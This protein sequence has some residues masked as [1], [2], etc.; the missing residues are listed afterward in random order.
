M[1]KRPAVDEGD[2]TKRIK[3]DTTLQSWRAQLD[4]IKKSGASKEQ[5]SI[6]FKSYLDKYVN[7]GKVLAMYIN[8]LMDGEEI[9]K[10]EIEKTFSET[11][12]RVLNIDL[13]KCYLKYIQLINPITPDSTDLPRQTVIKAYQFAVDTIG[14]DP[15]NGSEIWNDYL[16]YLYHW[17]CITSQESTKRQD[18][19]EKTL[20]K[21]IQTPSSNLE[22]HWKLFTSFEN[23]LNT[24]K[25][26]KVINDQSPIYMKLRSINN[27]LKKIIGSPC[28][29]IEVIERKET[30]QISIW[31][32]WL[33]WEFKNPLE[34]NEKALQARISLVYNLSCQY[35]KLNPEVWFNYSN[36]VIIEL[37]NLNLGKEILI[38]CLKINPTSLANLIKL[39]NIYESNNETEK[40]NPIWQSLV[41]HLID[42][43]FDNELITYC[44][45]NWMKIW[46]KLNNL[47]QIRFVFSQARKFTDIGFKIYVE[48]AMIEHSNNDNKIAIKAF[49]LG[50]KYFSNS[51][52]MVL[53]YLNFLIEIKDL[54]NFKKIIEI[55][56]ENFTNDDDLIKLFIKY[57]QV[58]SNFGNLNSINLL[59]KR[60][61]TK[62]PTSTSFNL[63][64]LS[65]T[66]ED[67]FN[68][69]LKLDKYKDSNKVDNLTDLINDNSLKIDDEIIEPKKE[70]IIPDGIYN[71]LR[72]L[73]N[74]DYY[75]EIPPIFD[76]D[77]S[78]EFLKNLNNSK[79]DDDKEETI[80][81][82]AN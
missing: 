37:K 2:V 15:I 4:L 59:T 58:E 54:T 47:K 42:E 74:A 52:E 68:P 3:S 60:Y 82:E 81:D 11:L 39:S 31:N 78:I 80:V 27:D 24:Q 77:K 61:L 40:I 28:K 13:W 35:L 23:D 73:P 26:R 53:Q 46:K 6:A 70:F 67:Y 33:N 50:L 10:A 7:D 56:I 30:N 41:K 55:S 75:K 1:S 29:L 5:V 12:T 57:Y 25:S 34:L 64:L 19:I 18:L 17:Q 76:L 72:V 66:N 48:Y 43:K 38:D 65:T 9:D 44:Y 21:L 32:K 49:E 14:I 16:N 71:L 63:L 45:I 51:I 69:L 20:L 8:Y 79:K 62:F 22:D 36:Y